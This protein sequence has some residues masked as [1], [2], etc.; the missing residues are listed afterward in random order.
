MK[1]FRDISK[2]ELLY[3]QINMNNIW[4]YLKIFVHL[5]RPK[6]SSQIN[7]GT[8]VI[9]A[10]WLEVKVVVQFVLGDAI[11]AIM[12]YIVG[13]AI[14]SVIVLKVVNVRVDNQTT[15]KNSKKRGKDRDQIVEECKEEKN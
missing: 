11:K 14:S 13:K 9:L 7:I 1:Q 4:K 8:F 10:T 2:R 3:S 6:N 5:I 15:V 12:L